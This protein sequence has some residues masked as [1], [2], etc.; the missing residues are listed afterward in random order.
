MSVH[1]LDRTDPTFVSD[2]KDS[3]V[4]V[5]E[6]V[7][8]INDQI[9]DAHGIS[10]VQ[11][12]VMDTKIRP[13][14]R[15]RKAYADDG[16]VKVTWTKNNMEKS[17]M[18]EFKQRKS[19]KFKTLADFRYEDVYVDSVYKFDRIRKRANT[20]GYILTD[21][22]M[23]CIFSTCL[24]VFEEHMIVKEQVFR[25][26]PCK[27]GSLPKQYFHEGMDNVCRMIVRLAA[28]YDEVDPAIIHARKIRRQIKM[29][30]S[31]IKSLEAQLNTQRTFLVKLEHENVEE[32]G[33]GS[34]SLS[35]S[36]SLASPLP[37][38]LFSR[39]KSKSN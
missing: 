25:N 34:G 13:D 27:W 28:S 29:T 1:F 30:R 2:L 31:K 17:A 7:R 9:Q 22:F 23:T 38:K 4:H 3:V 35:P 8:R 24:N 37:K 10:N 18:I 14:V 15:K 20:M 19:Y 39:R 12:H 32:E 33:G 16:D 5:N 6:V 36:S 26:R 21:Q 11:L